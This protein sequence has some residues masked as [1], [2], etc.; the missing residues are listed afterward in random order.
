MCSSDLEFRR[1]LFRSGGEGNRT[2]KRVAFFTGA[3]RS[4]VRSRG[5]QSTPHRIACA[6]TCVDAD[7]RCSVRPG[8]VTGPRFLPGHYAGG[9]GVLVEQLGHAAAAHLPERPRF[10][11]SDAF[12]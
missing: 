10:Q 8:V 11:H 5:I 1:V 3:V 12:A 2:E 9:A 4:A 6:A 7:E